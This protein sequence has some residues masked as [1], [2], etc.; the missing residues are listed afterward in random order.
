MSRIKSHTRSIFLVVPA[1]AILFLIGLSAFNKAFS[2]PSDESLTVL[3]ETDFTQDHALFAVADENIVAVFLESPSAE[4]ENSDTGGIGYDVI[5][6]RYRKSMNQTFCWQDADEGA[7]H[8]MSL[9]DTKGKEV[10]KVASNG[11]CV[12][13][14]IEPGDYEMRLYHDGKTEKRVA[15]FIVTEENKSTLSTTSEEA[16]SNVATFLDTNRCAGCDL[17][18]VNLFKADLSGVDLSDAILNDAILTEANLS[19]ADLSGAELRNADLSS[20]DLTGTNLTGA[21]LSG[22]IL[23]SADLTDA[24]LLHANLENTDT[25]GAIFTNTNLTGTMR[26]KT[27][28][29][30]KNS[31]AL[32]QEEEELKPETCADGTLAPGDGTKD[33]LISSTCNVGPGVYQYVN[34]NIIQ[35]GILNFMDNGSDIHFWAKSILVESNGSLLAGQNTKESAFGAKGATLTFHLY[36]KESET[37]GI[38]CKSPQVNTSQQCGIPTNITIN[39]RDTVNPTDCKSSTLP[40]PVTDCFYTYMNPHPSNNQTGF[41]GTKV[42]AVSYNGTL[43]LFGQKGATYKDVPNWDSGTSW[44]RLRNDKD[45]KPERTLINLDRDVDWQEGDR[46]VITTTD[47]LPGHSEELQIV[48]KLAPKALRVTIIDPQTNMPPDGCTSL[49]LDND[50]CGLRYLHNGDLYPDEDINFKAPVFSRLHLGI[51][52][53]NGST[54]DNGKNL[55]E[56]RAAVALLS[57][58]IRVVSA[59]DNIPTTEAG[60]M[61]KYDCFLTG[62]Y[63][64]HT[65]IRQGVKEV[66]IQGVEFYQLGQGGLKGRYPVHFHLMRKAPPDTFAKDNSVHDSMTRWYTIHGTEGVTL[67]R[68]VGYKSIGHGYYIEDGTEINNK[69]YSNIGIFA[70][71]A[72]KNEQNPRQVPGILG[73]SQ[74]G[75]ENQADVPYNSDIANPAVFWITNGWNDFE[76]NMAAGAGACGACYWLIP[77]GISGPSQNMYWEGYASIQQIPNPSMGFPPIGPNGNAPLKKF[78]GNYCSTAQ[79]SFNTVGA[80]DVCNGLAELGPAI[81]Q[82]APAP[83]PPNDSRQ[84]YYPR[85]SGLLNP[86]LCNKT[87]C[88]NEGCGAGQRGICPV[89]VIDRYTSAFHWPEKNFAAIW[90]RGKW[91]LLSNSVLSDSQNGGVG[92]VTGGDYTL[93]SVI[94]GNWQVAMKNVFIGYTQGNNA[95]ASNAGPFNPKGISCDNTANRQSYCLSKK[96]GVT[97]P[98]SN[99]SMQQRLFNVYDGPN[100]QDSN[101]Y[102]DIKTTPL[103]PDCTPENCPQTGPWMYTAA[104][105]VPIDHKTNKCVLPNAAI[106]WKQPNGFYYPPAFHSQ[107]LLFKNVDIRHLVIEPLWKPNSFESDLDQIK[108]NYCTFDPTTGINKTFQGFTAVDRQTVLNDDDGS[109]TGLLSNEFTETISVNLDQFFIAPSEA[110][111]CRSF[112]IA[113]VGGG[114]TGGTAKTSPYEYLTTVVY[115]KCAALGGAACD[116][117]CTNPKRTRCPA[118]G[119]CGTKFECVGIKWGRTCSNETCYGV[120]LTRQLFNDLDGSSPEDRTIPMMGMNFYQRSMLTLNHAAYYIDTTVSDEKQKMGRGAGPIDQVNVF[121]PNGTYYVFFVY[122]T[123][124]TKQEY[125]IYIGEGISDFESNKAKYISPVRVNIENQ[126]LRIEEGVDWNGLT[127]SY[128]D[129]TG[130][131]TVKTDFSEFAGDF[132]KTKTDYCQPSSFCAPSNGSCQSTL[133]ASDP[134]HAESQSICETWAGKDIDCPLYKFKDGR[135]LPGCIGFAVTLGDSDQFSYNRPIPDNTPYARCFPK[136][137]EPWSGV[138]LIDAGDIAGEGCKDQNIPNPQFCQ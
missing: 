16:L 89:T 132:Q 75:R 87:S 104:L 100:A 94:P 70:R 80:T 92:L 134:L 20:A 34:V 59:G 102:M 137:Q 29:A 98:V 133:P 1:L 77:T 57:R 90:L 15:V 107:N 32:N 13:K 25:K 72:I 61:C 93:S 67:A 40:G 76:Y 6:Y 96:E 41:F 12:T 116:G 64:G 82:D 45:A 108:K 131:M 60:R 127:G 105:G 26:T 11:D 23:I 9:T 101:L 63:G 111:E 56:T 130:I 36:G 103:A 49:P 55:A 24:N 117:T 86:T 123:E 5:P 113:K 53:R 8:Y 129:G 120:N 121:E 84:Y 79:F 122:P 110:P 48:K 21:D 46:I 138:K 42:L 81:N 50:K 118:V 88:V 51:Q 97:F 2:G 115:P 27:E 125:Q 99:F 73:R 128:D 44:V 119:T 68:N 83:P 95:L 14:V 114:T 135:T 74:P 4:V 124:R 47:Y 19:G 3:T 106:G 22:A 39:G 112:D 7:G 31:T 126:D 109:L 30:D 18:G 43:R 35:N 54:L 62:Y 58:S 66:K 85:I 91:I 33:L 71:A 52:I 65:M 38:T 69:F 28:D 136:D 78:E 37:A 10:L 17:S